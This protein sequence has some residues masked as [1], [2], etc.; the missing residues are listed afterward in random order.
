MGPIGL[1]VRE[2]PVWGWGAG[3]GPGWLCL[4]LGAGMTW[5][6]I[7]LPACGKPLWGDTPIS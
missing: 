3:V 4:A 7:P 5:K 1:R 6:E 2:G